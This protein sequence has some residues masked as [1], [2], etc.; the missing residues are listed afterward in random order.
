M[1]EMSDVSCRYKQTRALIF[2]SSTRSVWL[3]RH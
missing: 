1:G 3:P 2:C